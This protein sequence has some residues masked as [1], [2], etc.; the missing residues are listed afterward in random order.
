MH[1]PS[2]RSQHKYQE[3]FSIC[4]SAVW[5]V[6]LAGIFGRTGNILCVNDYGTLQ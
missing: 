5:W 1:S 4:T 2:S 6:E 3:D